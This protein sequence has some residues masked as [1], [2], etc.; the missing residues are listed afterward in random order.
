MLTLTCTC[1]GPKCWGLQNLKTPQRSEIS[2][3][4]LNSLY[5]QS[6]CTTS[7]ANRET[8]APSETLNR[9]AKRSRSILDCKISNGNDT[10]SK[11][12]LVILGTTGVNHS[13]K[14]LELH[15]HKF[16]TRKPEKEPF[17]IRRFVILAIA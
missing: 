6:L 8:R 14:N 13:S 2:Q 1:E 10:T 9:A 17:L 4:S 16:C 12:C 5:S 7:C 15:L 11:F 3:I